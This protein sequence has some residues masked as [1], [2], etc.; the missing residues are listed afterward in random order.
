MRNA[1]D[2]SRRHL[3]LAGAAAPLLAGCASHIGSS[4]TYSATTEFEAQEYIW[5]TWGENGFL[6]GEPMT[7]TLLPLISA[8]APHVKVRILYNA[9]TS[10]LEQ[11]E[12]PDP[13][14]S[15]ESM[16]TRI[17]AELSAAGIPLSQIDFQLAPRLF[18][19]L[20]D[21]GPVFLRGPDGQLAIADFASVLPDPMAS[22]LDR[23]LTDGMGIPAISS[24]MVSDGG[25]RQ[26]NGRGVMMVGGGYSD[27]VNPGMTRLEREAEYRR[28]LGV[29]HVVWL[30]HGPRD[31]DYGPLEDGRWGI[32][33]G[34]HIDEFC[35]FVDASTVI[36]AE[37]PEEERT[38]DSVH[39]KTHRRMEENFA[40][41]SGARDPN[42]K[43]FRILR[44]PT[45]RAATRRM[46]FDSMSPMEQLWFEGAA[47]GQ[48][49]EFYLPGSYL[50]FVI[51]NGVV[52]TSKYWRPGM[53]AAIR[54]RDA[55]GLAAVQAAFPDRR[56]VQIDATP[57]QHDGG[58]IHC[59]TRNQPVA[60]V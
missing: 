14:R 38:L 29:E 58:G 13:P 7:R 46:N 10:W 21:P 50:N 42:G 20:Q 48:D 17:A 26:C 57:L 41:L 19:A 51:A 56:V 5:L 24:E 22:R 4:E 49:I 31:E 52:V 30:E 36:L 44:A 1:S 18:G 3:L 35:R 33:T 40:L 28:V 59:Y 11:L 6:G 9:W 43:P 23:V 53:D 2:W 39:A 55:E 27:R 34:G 12:L 15:A 25:N 54:V 37:V 47:A 60:A 16:R 45:A 32:G 8:L